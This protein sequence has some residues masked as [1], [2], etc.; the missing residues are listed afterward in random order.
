M[1]KNYI[2]SLLIF[3]LT[4]SSQSLLQAAGEGDLD[5]L[6]RQFEQER[7]SRIGYTETLVDQP[8]LAAPVNQ[9]AL[10]EVAQRAQKPPYIPPVLTATNKVVNDNL[11]Q[12]AQ[13]LRNTTPPTTPDQPRRHDR[14]GSATRQADWRDESYPQPHKFS[15][16]IAPQDLPVQQVWSSDLYK[17]LMGTISVKVRKE[18]TDFLANEIEQFIFIPKELQTPAVLNREAARIML[19]AQKADLS[20]EAKQFLTSHENLV[21]IGQEIPKIQNPEIRKNVQSFFDDNVKDF[22]TDAAKTT[23]Y[24]TGIFAAIVAVMTLIVFA[25]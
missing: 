9:Q 24:G 2:V 19:R 12:R 25:T 3:G 15:L 11:D 17:K 7:L 1:K 20:P 14:H 21:A 10:A 5:A 13:D 4:F 6:M 18:I 16:D 8:A 23:L 22:F